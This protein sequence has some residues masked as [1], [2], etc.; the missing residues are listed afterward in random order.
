M[1][2]IKF[3]SSLFNLLTLAVVRSRILRLP[4]KRQAQFIKTLV[5]G[6]LSVTPKKSFSIRSSTECVKECLIFNEC[7]TYSIDS[8]AKKCHLHDKNTTDD[9]V[10]V[11]ERKGLTYYQTRWDTKKVLFNNVSNL[12]GTKI[13]IF[14]LTNL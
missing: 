5:N 2:F 11:I 7:K 6:T 1:T 12:Y 4:C 8:K 3:H 10:N 14:F 13:F 9:G